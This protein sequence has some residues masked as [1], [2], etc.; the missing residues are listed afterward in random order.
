MNKL[1]LPVYYMIDF[2]NSINSS[3]ASLLIM[4]HVCVRILALVL[5]VEE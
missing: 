2:T 3:R 5:V 1:L 4:D